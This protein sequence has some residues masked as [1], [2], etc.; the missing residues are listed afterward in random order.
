MEEKN[1]ASEERRM[2]ESLHVLISRWKEGTFS[3]I[4]DDWKWIFSYSVRYRWAIV[5]YT[6][7][8]II[9]TSLGLVS[10]VAGKY[11][12]DII[13]GYETS[14]LWLLVCI[15]VGSM[16]FSLGFKSVTNRISTKLSIYINNDI[17]ADIFDKIVDADWL[18]LNQYSNGDVLNRFN[19]DISTVSGNAISWLPSI[20]IAVYHFV[21][22]FLVIMH[23]DT[24]D[25]V[26]RAFERA[27]FAAYVQN[28]HKEAEGIQPKNAGNEQQADD[29]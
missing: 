12:I 27:V 22:T 5:F 15:M 3:E 28:A 14:K 26:Y 25:G 19:S 2:F 24:G 6:L 9:S 8:G 17:Q 13:T 20:I 1:K 11:M 16:V 18:S 4:L 21:A 10:S 23:Y 7:L 29:V